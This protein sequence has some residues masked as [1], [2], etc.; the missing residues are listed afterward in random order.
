M[1]SP[2]L[3]ALFV[4][5][6]GFVILITSC[7][8]SLRSIPESAIPG[9]SEKEIESAARIKEMNQ[10]LLMSMA[11][12]KREVHQDYKIGPEDLLEISVFEDERLNKILRVSSQGN[13]NFPMLG[14]V[15]V[16]GLT[17]S[18]L[19]K[20][21]HDLLAEKYF[22]DPNVNVFIKEYRN[23]Q[24]SVLGSVL[25]PGAYEFSGQRMVLDMLGAA[26]GLQENAGMLL[27]LIRPPRLEAELPKKTEEG[28]LAEEKPLTFVVD[29]EELLGKGNLALNLPLMNGDVIN[30][31]VSGKVYV[32]GEVKSP[33][34]FVKGK[35]LTLSQA[36]VMAGGLKGIANASETRIFRFGMEGAE[37]RV[38]IMDVYAIQKG[39]KEDFH[40]KENDIVFVPR[41]EVKTVLQEIWDLMKNPIAGLLTFSTL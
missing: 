36:I 27:F 5:C 37:K 4:T 29:L 35:N 17:A 13:I 41:S 7:A 12:S 34:G 9:I 31:P 6:L 33:S 20:E 22:Q 14:V 8:S 23:Q 19:E 15:K 28:E 11:S 21:I 38:I 2:R 10:R 32:G 3:L 40:L 25:K 18:E 39:Q 16:K 30:I 24:I 1:M 26:G